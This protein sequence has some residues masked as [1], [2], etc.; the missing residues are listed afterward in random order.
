MVLFLPTLK[1]LTWLFWAILRSLFWIPYEKMHFGP[2]HNI[3]TNLKERAAAQARGGVF[4][5]SYLEDPRL[6]DVGLQMARSLGDAEL[7]RVLNREPE[8]ETVALGGKGVVLV[9]TDG[10]YL[11]GGEPNP[12]QL[13]RLL[14]LIQQG[15]DAQALVQDALARQTGDNVTALVWQSL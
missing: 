2:D 10:L 13:T 8:I 1:T 14:K 4:H 15:A 9:G 3:I 5:G 11:P 12:D 6:P 7:A